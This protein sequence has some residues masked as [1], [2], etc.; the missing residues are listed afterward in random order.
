MSERQKN[1]FDKTRLFLTYFAF[2]S[3]FCRAYKSTLTAVKAMNRFLAIF[4]ITIALL[5]GLLYAMPRDFATFVG[6]I[7]PDGKVCVY[8]RQTSLQGY[9][10]GFCKIVE[11]D[12][13][14]LQR[15]LTDCDKVDGVSVTFEGGRSDVDRVAQAL[16]V[17]GIAEY[18]L[19]D[20]S[21]FCGYSYKINGGVT[22]DGN[23]VN[24]QIAFGK[25]TVTV[26]S[27]LILGSY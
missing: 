19:D 26:G 1:H 13:Q 20:V 22:L 5:G 6:Q 23:R 9:D 27:P 2:V 4:F 15:I 8:C 3:E 14:D 10:L 17:N 16:G 24:V 12:A 18:Q 21:V 25:G 11:C 7:S